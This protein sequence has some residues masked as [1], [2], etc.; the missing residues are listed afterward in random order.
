MKG[1]ERWDAK[2]AARILAKYV[3]NVAANVVPFISTTIYVEKKKK[4][5]ST[6]INS[7]PV[8]G[9]NLRKD[10]RIMKRSYKEFNFRQKTIDVIEQANSIIIEYADDGYDLTLRQLYYQF[11]ARDLIPN[12]QSEY[13]KLG[14][15]IN[16]ARLSGWIDWNSIVDRTRKQQSNS[17]WDSPA[18]IIASAASGYGIDTRADQD[19][20]LEV[21]VEKDALVGVIERACEPLDVGYLSCRGY[22][23]QS[24]MWRA[25]MRF[26]RNNADNKVLLHLGDHDPSGIDMTRDIQ[27]R[28]DMFGANVSVERIALSMKQIKQHSPPPNP[29][30][31]TD[32]RYNSYRDEYGD[33][34]WELDALDPR[35]ITKL[36]TKHIKEY[37][38]ED[39][40]D[41]LIEK[42]EL[43]RAKLQEISD[44]WS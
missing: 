27:D 2:N 38:D 42:Q 18:D 25:A 21:W 9:L 22:V 3:L 6:L 19:D 28:L 39:K 33:E 8:Q 41:F 16:D 31:T 30:K 35:F 29:A 15:V 24:A 44:N 11:V 34:S 5:I 17:H 43:D 10:V 14:S 40:R 13:K 1:S 26:K 12:K 36:I 20:Y 7:Y 37:T 32:S 23:S 4:I